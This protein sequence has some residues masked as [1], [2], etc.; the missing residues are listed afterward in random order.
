MRPGHAILAWVLAAALAV[1]GLLWLRSIPAIVEVPEVPEGVE[2]VVIG[3][4]LAGYAVPWLSPEGGIL[5][6][7]R[8][9]VKWVTGAITEART[10]DLMEIAL[11]D[12]D[13][14]TVLVEMN[15]FVMKNT[16]RKPPADRTVPQRVAILL[17]GLTAELQVGLN[18]LGNK[19]ENGLMVGEPPLG[20]RSWSAERLKRQSTRRD[21]LG[22]PEDAV[23]LRAVLA[24]ARE[25]GREVIFFEPPRPASTWEERSPEGADA[26]MAHFA[27][28]ADE[29][30]VP[31]W[32][33]G[34]VWPDSLFRD[35][36][37]LDGNGRARFLEE[38]LRVAQSRDGGASR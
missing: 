31:F 30:G 26:A 7:G 17:S 3:S 20:S 25:T 22:A 15:A 14:G 29:L 4:S 1:G 27:A 5:G 6:D 38:L 19:V 28:L 10:L 24:R 12:P 16:A 33:F 21:R 2:V 34:P 23:R 37:H 8:R 9:H 13:V 18:T 32:P 11:A 35:A 36:G